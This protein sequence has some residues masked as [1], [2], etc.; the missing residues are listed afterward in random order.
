M[1]AEMMPDAG[2]EELATGVEAT[3]KQVMQESV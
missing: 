3:L 1:I 2:L